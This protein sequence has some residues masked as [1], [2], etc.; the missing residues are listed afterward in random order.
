MRAAGYCPLRFHADFS[1]SAAA[2]RSSARILAAADANGGVCR[3]LL[4]TD[5][6]VAAELDGLLDALAAGNC[7]PARLN[8]TTAD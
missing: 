3:V 2:L 6:S 1:G 8:E 4:G 7:T 5:A